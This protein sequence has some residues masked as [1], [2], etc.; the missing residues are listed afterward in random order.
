MLLHPASRRLNI[1]L[2]IHFIS[3]SMQQILRPL[4]GPSAC[5]SRNL[6]PRSSIGG[7]SGQSAPSSFR[8]HGPPGAAKSREDA[9]WVLTVQRLFPMFVKALRNALQVCVI[10]CGNRMLDRRGLLAY[11]SFVRA[12]QIA[13]DVAFDKPTR[14]QAEFWWFGL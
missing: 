13:S 4:R 10:S 6:R 11:K 7:T 14:R 8:L 12:L 1:P 9:S 5:K 3:Q 2:R